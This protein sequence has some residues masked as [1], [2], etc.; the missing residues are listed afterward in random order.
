MYLAREIASLP[1]ADIGRAFNMHHSTVM[2]ATDSV[3]D[4]MKRDPEFHRMV[5]ALL[6]SIH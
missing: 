4:R 1:F 3:R 5:Q 6:N 2:N